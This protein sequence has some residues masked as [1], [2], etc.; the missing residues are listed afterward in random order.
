MYVCMYVCM[1]R[2]FLKTMFNDTLVLGF[3]L[4]VET[5]ACNAPADVLLLESLPLCI[6]AEKALVYIHYVHI[7]IHTRIHH[8][9]QRLT[10]PPSAD[11]RKLDLFG[12]YLITDFCIL[13]E[14]FH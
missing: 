5:K 9:F 6:L 10:P 13:N 3:S 4:K 14:I 12:T 7:Y 1:Y 11:T 2:S 8:T